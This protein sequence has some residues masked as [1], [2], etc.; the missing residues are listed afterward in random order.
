MPTKAETPT[1]PKR[2]RAREPSPFHQGSV[3]RKTDDGL[4]IYTEEE[5]RIGSGGGMQMYDSEADGSKIQICVHLIVNAAF[6]Y[7]CF[8]QANFLL[9]MNFYICLL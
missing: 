3:R 7:S 8:I 1:K 9:F 2:Q 4:T 6:R 5:L